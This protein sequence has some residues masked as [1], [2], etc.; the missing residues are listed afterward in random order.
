MSSRKRPITALDGIEANIPFKKQKLD[1][2]CEMI[3]TSN[4]FTDPNDQNQFQQI[5][6]LLEQQ[7][8]HINPQNVNKQIAEYRMDG[9][10]RFSFPVKGGKPDYKE[11]PKL[12][13]KSKIN[14]KASYF[15]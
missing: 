6:K 1:A 11:E 9:S 10:V 14:I 3:I 13:S 2:K 8:N 5:F 7:L 4:I 15:I 12:Y